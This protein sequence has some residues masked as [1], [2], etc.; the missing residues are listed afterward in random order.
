MGRERA[1]T[2]IA[3]MVTVSGVLK[4]LLCQGKQVNK[5]ASKQEHH[6]T[7]RS[8]WHQSGASGVSAVSLTAAANGPFGVHSA[9]RGKELKLL[10]PPPPPSGN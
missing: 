1:A 7:R 4:R 2:T 10:P 5:Q 8:A 6:R 9:R 3:V